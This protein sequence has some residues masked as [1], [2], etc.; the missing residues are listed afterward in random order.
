MICNQIKQVNMVGQDFL[1]NIM[2]IRE[3]IDNTTSQTKL[4]GLFDDNEK[5]ILNTC[6]LLSMAFSHNK[7]EDELKYT[8][9]LQYWKRIRETLVEKLAVS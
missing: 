9:Q 4:R 1:M 3:D 5:A 8:A 7:L 6:S 2:Q